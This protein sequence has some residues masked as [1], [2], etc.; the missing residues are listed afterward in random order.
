MISR[1]L[2][3]IFVTI[4]TTSAISPSLCSHLADQVMLRLMSRSKTLSNPAADD[5]KL[6][7]THYNH[8]R[9]K[10]NVL[11]KDILGGRGGT[12]LVDLK[13][14]GGKSCHR[15]NNLGRFLFNP[16]FS[17]SFLCVSRSHFLTLFAEKA[18]QKPSLT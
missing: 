16:S 5:P 1:K 13:E 18:N 10:F 15:P 9:S 7:C 17:K 11:L 3:V 6:N 14:C 8:K 12:D 2:L 4:P